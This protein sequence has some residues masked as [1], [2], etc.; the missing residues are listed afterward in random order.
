MIPTP[1]GQRKS[2]CVS[3]RVSG[4]FTVQTGSTADGGRQSESQGGPS[5]R[6]A[7]RCGHPV[8]L[9]QVPRTAPGVN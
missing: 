1:S 5:G 9:R 3:V 7:S 8:H 2:K 6:Q 4:R